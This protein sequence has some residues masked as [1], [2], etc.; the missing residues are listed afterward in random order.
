MII[1]NV[2]NKKEE[3]DEDEDDVNKINVVQKLISSRV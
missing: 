1:N 2:H 3:E